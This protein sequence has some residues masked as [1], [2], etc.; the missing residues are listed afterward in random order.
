MDETMISVEVNTRIYMGMLNLVGHKNFHARCVPEIDAEYE[1]AE[2][3][4]KKP[5][6]IGH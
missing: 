4:F 2:A 6:G 5:A 3:L 1:G